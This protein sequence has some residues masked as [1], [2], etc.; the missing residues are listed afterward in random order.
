MLSAG[1]K[2]PAFCLQD[3]N[4]SPHSLTE[5]LSRGPVLLVFFKIS[6][7]TCQLTLP[8]LERIA[9]GKLPIVAISQDDAAGTRRFQAKFGVLPTLLDTEDEGY[10]ASNAFAIEY[11]PSQFLVESDGTISLTSEGFVQA[12]LE[13]IAARATLPIFRASESVPAWKAG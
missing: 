2:A 7:P 10:P 4:G 5:I 8:F 6:C 1:S 12:D 11:V 3:L 9:Q 13:S